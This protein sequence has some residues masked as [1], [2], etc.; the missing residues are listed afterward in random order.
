MSRI[1][2]SLL[3]VAGFVVLSASTSAQI[4]QYATDISL[5]QLTGP[6]EW[7]DIDNDNDLDIIMMGMTITGSSIGKIA[8][9]D[10][11]SY[12]FHNIPSLPSLGLAPQFAL[13]DWDNDGDMDILVNTN[14]YGI[15]LLS[16]EMGIFVDSNIPFNSLGEPR[17][18]DWGDFDS[19]GDLDLIMSG[20]S[21]CVVYR[22]NL[23]DPIYPSE[24]TLI[25]NDLPSAGYADVSWGDYDSDGDLDVLLSGVILQNNNG[26]F[27][28]VIDFGTPGV[29]YGAV[30]WGDTDNDN[31]LDAIGYLHWSSPGIFW[32]KNND[33][34]DIDSL[35]LSYDYS[36]QF[37]DVNNDGS[38]DLLS[39]MRLSLYTDQTFVSYEENTL[40]AFGGRSRFGDY[41]NDLDLD[42]VV[43]GS[44]V[45]SIHCKVINNVDSLRNNPPEPPSGL[46]SMVLPNQ[47]VLLQWN[48]AFD[49]ES[50]SLQSISELNS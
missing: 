15:H 41:D 13:T 48:R 33:G 11:G 36:Y 44:R 30:A 47:R 43:S 4:F 21:R 10:S 2:S 38:L 16:N 18:I 3:K 40:G 31:D 8:I 42:L 39:P 27:Q 12:T 17:G 19:D 24:F 28:E 25:Q 6:V 46:S 14:G 22:N 5:P 37:G 9:N 45:G 32:C 29:H 26:I 34:F 1:L 49:E 35:P 50:V 20:A 7:C 23:G